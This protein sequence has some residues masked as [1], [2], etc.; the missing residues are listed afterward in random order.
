ML[1][2]EAATRFISQLASGR[3]IEIPG[4]G[5]H[6]LIDQPDR[7]L[8]ALEAFIDRTENFGRESS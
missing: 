5:H 7:L 4:A 6:V 8:L 1:S 3:L 2:S